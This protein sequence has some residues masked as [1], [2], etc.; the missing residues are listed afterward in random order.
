MHRQVVP[1]ATPAPRP[2]VRVWAGAALLLASL[3]LIGLGGCFLIGVM[4]LVNPAAGFGPAKSP[5]TTPAEY[6]LMALL[7]VLAFACFSAA[8]LLMVIGVR[9]LWRIV[10]HG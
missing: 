6:V 3:G 5:N 7:Y 1:Y 9:W 8:A 4:M 2:H 10:H